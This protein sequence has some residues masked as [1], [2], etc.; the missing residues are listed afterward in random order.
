MK[1]RLIQVALFSHLYVLDK[2]F[3]STKVFLTEQT[4]VV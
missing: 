2:Q 3:I 1:D 4:N